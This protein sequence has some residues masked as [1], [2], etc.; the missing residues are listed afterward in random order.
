MLARM[1]ADKL[2][3]VLVVDDERNI[4]RTLRLVLESEQ[5][6]V[7]DAESAEQGLALLDTHPVDC[8]L[9]DLKLP[10][11]SGLD[12]LARLQ[13]AAAPGE[14]TVPVVVISG[15]GTVSDAVQALSLI[16]I[17]A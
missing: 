13:D 10:G 7:L 8:V 9:L 4:R 12:A 1:Q 11:L 6:L 3:T 2:P 5:Y 15:H 17:Y 16:H 14:T